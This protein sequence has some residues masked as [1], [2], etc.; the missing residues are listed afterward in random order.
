VDCVVLQLLGDCAECGYPVPI[1]GV[2]DRVVCCSCDA[3]NPLDV[4]FWQQ[5][6]LGVSSLVSLR[7]FPVIEA[8]ELVAG[9][10]RVRG[11]YGATL[12]ACPAC[13][14]PPLDITALAGFA[15]AGACACPTCGQTLTVRTPDERT[16][17][18][19]PYIVVIVGEPT[20]DPATAAR[21][22]EVRP[23]LFSC[24]GCGGTLR[25][26]G[27]T[28]VV[29]CEHCAQPSYLPDGLWRQ[30]RKVPRSRPFYLLCENG[31][32]ERAAEPFQR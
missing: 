32:Q 24:L 8:F 21:D 14:G 30:L 6:L 16:R 27:T 26:D 11:R 3:A 22:R 2:V 28:R 1:P 12:P 17:L 19:A 31:W 4:G 25:V 7:G 15:G 23:I 13:E 20:P 10:A 18:V 5:V 29:T 9:M